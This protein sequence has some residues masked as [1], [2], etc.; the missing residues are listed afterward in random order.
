MEWNRQGGQSDPYLSVENLKTRVQIPRKTRG[1]KSQILELPRYDP[2]HRR[3]CRIQ[4]ENVSEAR[5]L[6][7]ENATLSG[8]GEQ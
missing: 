2:V 3:A 1:E 5:R 8:G 7:P 4:L 6:A